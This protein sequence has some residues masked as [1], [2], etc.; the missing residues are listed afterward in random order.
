MNTYLI[1]VVYQ[2]LPLYYFFTLS[3]SNSYIPSLLVSFYFP[4]LYCFFPCIYL[5][6][7]F[8]YF[9][10]P[11]TSLYWF[12]LSL[13]FSVLY[14]QFLLFL[15]FFSLFGYIFLFFTPYVTTNLVVF[16]CCN[17]WKTSLYCTSWQVFVLESI[18]QTLKKNTLTK[19][20]G[21]NAAEKWI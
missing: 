2:F 5:F 3:L 14:I 4:S 13:F 19:I 11:F 8:V 16:C 7:F 17:G 1:V 6:I 10:H 18:I 12:S 20:L 9:V 15:C 21:I